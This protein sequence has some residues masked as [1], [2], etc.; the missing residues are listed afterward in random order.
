A[1]AR[2]STPSWRAR[3][4]PSAWPIWFTAAS[5]RRAPPSWPPCTG[6]SPL[7]TA[8]CSSSISPKWTPLSRPCTTWRGGSATP[9]SR[10][11]PPPATAVSPAPGRGQ[12]PPPFLGPQALFHTPPPPPPRPPLS[13]PPPPPPPRRESRQ[14]PLAPHPPQQSLVEDHPRASRLGRRPQQ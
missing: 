1:A 9:P 11:R 3:P 8:S 7:T 4:I 12:T 5:R 13:R 6:V 14:T 10:F 2:S